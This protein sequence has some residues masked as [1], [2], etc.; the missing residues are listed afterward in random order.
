MNLLFSPFPGDSNDKDTRL[1]P[2]SF[3]E[4]TWENK[5]N[6]TFRESF[7]FKPITCS[8]TIVFKNY[9]SFIHFVY[10]FWDSE[11]GSPLISGCGYIRASE[12]GEKK[13]T[14]VASYSNKAASFE[15]GQIEN[16]VH[17]PRLLF[18]TQIKAEGSNGIQKLTKHKVNNCT[19]HWIILLYIWYE[20]NLTF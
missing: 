11:K 5:G 2:I 13:F 12:E 20:S 6:G 19:L 10:T 4:G 16:W 17:N 14:L 8:S 9:D 1:E 3:L 15:S 18:T 7:K